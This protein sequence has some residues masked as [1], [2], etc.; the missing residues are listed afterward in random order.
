MTDLKKLRAA[1][2]ERCNSG[3]TKSFEEYVKEVGFD[4][5]DL[6]D[7]PEDYEDGMA[8]IFNIVINVLI[9]IGVVGLLMIAMT[10][11]LFWDF[12]EGLF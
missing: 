7:P 9:A 4:F 5:D 2:I 1:Y 8:Q 10:V 12:I 6:P 3:Y 11:W